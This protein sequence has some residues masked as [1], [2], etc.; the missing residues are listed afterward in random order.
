MAQITKFLIWLKFHLKLQ[1]CGNCI[2]E[3]LLLLGKR[4]TETKEI[5][6]MGDMHD[7]NEMVIFVKIIEMVELA[8]RVK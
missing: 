8:N 7:I 5:A 4:V 6:E 3:K 1:K 2:L